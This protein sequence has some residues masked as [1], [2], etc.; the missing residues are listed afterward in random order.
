MPGVGL[1]CSP[2]AE[3]DVLDPGFVGGWRAIAVV[4]EV[5]A[6]VDWSVAFWCGGPAAGGLRDSGAVAVAGDGFEFTALLSHGE[7]AVFESPG[8]ITERFPGVAAPKAIFIE[9]LAEGVGPEV[10]DGG[11]LVFTGVGRVRRETA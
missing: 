11:G 4:G 5:S 6:R 8:P 2:A 10:E 7:N 3:Y 1:Q 9:G